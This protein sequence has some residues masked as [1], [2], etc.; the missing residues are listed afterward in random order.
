MVTRMQQRRDTTANWAASNPILRVGEMGYDTDV[1]RFKIGD[2]ITA[3]LSLPFLLDAELTAAQAAADAAETA[4]STAA[5]DAASAATAAVQDQVD[6][7]EGYADDAATSAAAA[8]A[9]GTTNDT[10]IAGRINDPASATALAL[11]ASYVRFLDQNGD[12][13]PPGS[14][15]TIFVNTTTGE[16]DDIVFEEA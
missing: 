3:W 2:G 4:A 9:V 16:I 1:D 6:A 5:S 11:T 13:L 12:P 10:I 8:A 7:A 15:T 14:V